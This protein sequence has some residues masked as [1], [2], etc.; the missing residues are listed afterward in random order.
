[1]KIVNFLRNL[2]QQ[3]ASSKTA[4]TE[5]VTTESQLPMGYRKLES[6]AN[7]FKSLAI[8]LFIVVATVI[9]S[10]MAYGWHIGIISTDS[11]I[12]VLTLLLEV[13]QNLIIV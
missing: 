4:V 7:S 8:T 2:L 9:M 5:N 6:L 3:N 10:F 1:M 13:L 12:K 11:L